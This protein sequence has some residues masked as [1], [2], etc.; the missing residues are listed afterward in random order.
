VFNFW[1][2][3]PFRVRL[4]VVAVLFLIISIVMLCVAI[5]DPAH[6][7]INKYGVIIRIAP[8]IFLVW[9]A[10]YD[11]IRIPFWVYMVSVPVLLVCL[12]RPML[13]FYVIPLTFFFLFMR[14]GHSKR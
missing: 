10:W 3:L 6:Y 11:L 8:I 1:F 13:F 14:T 2:R 4:G 7:P 5:G 12:I 9:I